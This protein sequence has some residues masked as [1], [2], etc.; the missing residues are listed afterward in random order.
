[1]KIN[2]VVAL[3]L[4]MSLLIVGCDNES[5][6][7]DDNKQ[8]EDQTEVNEEPSNE[9][10]EELDNSEPI[11]DN[12]DQIQ[13]NEEESENA[14]D[15]SNSNLKDGTYTASAASYD[16]D[17]S[18]E[19]TI[20]DS[21]ISDIKL[22]DYHDSEPVIER[23]FPIIK[24]RIIEANS[25]DV[26]SVSA[27]TFSTYAV[28]KATLDALEQA[29]LEEGDIEISKSTGYEEDRELAD[30]EDKTTDLLII[31]AGPAG[32]SAAIQ[33]KQD[34]VENVT[35]IE[36]LDILSGNG[37]FDMNFFDLANSE[38]MKAND[39]EI[40]KEEYRDNYK[41]NSWDSD[42]RV[43]AMTEGAFELDQWLRDQDI[44]LEYNFGGDGSTSHMA[45]AD[46]YAGDYIQKGL[47]NTAQ[48][49]GVEIITGTKATDL[50]IE[51]NIAKGAVVEDKETKYNI[52]AE[53]TVIA[54]G[55]FGSNKQLLEEY[56]EG[57]EVLPTSNQMGTTGDFVEIAKDHNIKLGDM[58]KPSIFPKILDPR[59]DLTGAFDS[60]FV[61]VNENGE[62]FIDET[63]SGIEYGQA[64]MDAKPVYYIFDEEA[65]DSFYR[66]TNQ[67]DKGYIAK[68]DSIEDLADA[69]SCDAD[70]LK[71]SLEAYNDAANGNIDDTFREENPERPLDLDNGLYFVKVTPALHMT[72]GGIVANSKA[73]VLDNDDNIIKGLY[74]AGEVTD[75]SG[76]YTASV[77]FGRISGSSAANYILE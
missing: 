72:K 10:I 4:S 32:L 34:G 74:A 69:I 76:A 6:T 40:S 27:A 21:K 57:A 3:A 44:T 53:S 73:E 67:V 29:G 49:L 11:N 8:V 28:K 42:D 68:A 59:R 39:N 46:E 5:S 33:A 9:E 36:K 62:R 70:T 61:Y 55:G 7:D 1:M 45:K 35:L 48:R 38:A 20:A 2:K 25:P 54:T 64:M 15:L 23:A 60:N 56:I 37:K 12:E 41:E 18:I 14:N 30:A 66:L 47:E 52:N 13:S 63:S 75:T 58:E 51:D 31:G 50:I 26:D 16:R 65:K 77:V 24:D 22:L 19:L 17:L 43:D 71:A